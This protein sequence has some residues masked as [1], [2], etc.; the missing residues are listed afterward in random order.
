[1]DLICIM[2]MGLMALN[3]KKDFETENWKNVMIL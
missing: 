3:L 1:M 2:L